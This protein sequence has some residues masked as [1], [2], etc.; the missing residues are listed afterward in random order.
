MGKISDY[1]GRFPRVYWVAM[2]FEL[3]ERGAYYTFTPIISW[4]AYYNVGLP[5]WLSFIILSFIW[6]I[7]YGLPILS[8]ALV[9]KVGYRRQIL[10]AFTILTIAYVSLSQ[11]STTVSLI[12]SVIAL[13]FGI[14]TYKPLISAI[15]AKVTSSEDRTY[16]FGIYYW[17][18]NIAAGFFP[19]FFVI[20]EV[21][22]YIHVGTY[23]IIFM[24][25]AI[26][27]SMNLIVALFIFEDVPRSEK[28]KTVGD[29]LNNIKT[30]MKD[31]KFMILVLLVALFWALYSTQLVGII[32]IIYG[33]KF[34]PEWF[35]LMVYAIFNP[36]TI[37]AVGPFISKYIE[38]VESIRVMI[39]G[40]LVYII[41]LSVL[42]F[43]VTDW[44]TVVFGI[45][46][47]SVGEFMVAPGFYSFTSKL[48]TEDKVSAYIGSTFVAS[49]IGLPLGAFGFGLMVSYIA[50][51]LHMPWL[52]FGIMISLCL[53]LFVF[54]LIYYQKWGQSVIQRAKRI[55][56]EEEGKKKE[57]DKDY[58]EPF[59]FR[60][61][62]TKTPILISLVLIPIVLFA[63]FSLG[64]AT[65]YGRDELEDE[66]D[67]VPPFDPMHYIVVT[68]ASTTHS[69]TLDEGSSTT[70]TFTV[71]IGEGELL[72]EGQFLKNITFVLTWTDDP[73][74]GIFGQQ[75][76][77]PDIFEIE[78]TYGDWSKL[79]WQGNEHGQQ[80]RLR[81]AS[82]EIEHILTNSTSGTGDWEI[83]VT[84]RNAG[85]YTL[86]PRDREVINDTSNAYDLEVI[87]KVYSTE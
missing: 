46:I 31:R 32:A 8:G 52:F 60:L 84:L 65:F 28:V 41:G 13:G 63:T 21:L 75:Q 49:F 14:G 43:G 73:D 4:H 25:G 42:G 55:A 72:S 7:Q 39:A 58:V 27:V 23:H 22:G 78:V 76:N 24:V 50:E 12:L 79:V 15:V 59:I 11:A 56:E 85:D 74:G 81:I 37:V 77:L 6:P 16:A 47:M 3:F 54:F 71:E 2:L 83:K 69:G 19:I 29:A 87:T 62:E 35:S 68:P 86:G 34:V 64:T 20:A 10:V 48:A 40:V 80:G 1:F 17:I 5:F 26:M 61:F 51:G 36:M 9:E 18:V 30:S 53:M 57:E 66:R 70:H 82:D 38:K 33:F 44:R 67:V 45:I